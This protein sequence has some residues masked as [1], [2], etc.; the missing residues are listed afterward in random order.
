MKLLKKFRKKESVEDAAAQ[1]ARELDAA[2]AAANPAEMIG[3]LVPPNPVAQ[4]DSNGSAGVPS[5]EAEADA[6]AAPVV[7]DSADGRRSTRV[8]RAPSTATTTG[9]ARAAIPRTRATKAATPAARR[10][11]KAPAPKAATRKTA[12]GAVAPATKK[13]RATASPA[14]KSATRAP[15]TTRAAATGQPVA[16]KR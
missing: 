5:P 12:S 9:A 2:V 15:R 13:P 3:S 16:K 14:K 10:A 1:A 11:G 8:K 7:T 4:E 6:G